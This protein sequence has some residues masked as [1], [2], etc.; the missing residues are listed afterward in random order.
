MYAITSKNSQAS[1][2]LIITDHGPGAHQLFDPEVA[3]QMTDMQAEFSLPDDKPPLDW[4]YT[5]SNTT[6]TIK[7]DELSVAVPREAKA[8]GRVYN[9]CIYVDISPELAPLHIMLNT[10]MQLTRERHV[11]PQYSSAIVCLGMALE[12]LRSAESAQ[13]LFSH[14]MARFT[15]G[16]VALQE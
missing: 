12:L 14:L 2:D 10:G 1:D 9:K 7:G 3:W 11:I 6:M 5:I 16:D 4:E 8:V 15:S 13:P